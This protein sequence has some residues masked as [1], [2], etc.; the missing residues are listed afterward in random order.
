MSQ[1]KAEQIIVIGASEH[2]LKNVSLKI[3]RDTLTVF[4]GVSGSG[5]SSL[6]LILFSKKVSAVL[7]N[8]F[9]PMRVNFSDN[10]TNQKSSIL[11]D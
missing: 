6:H 4:T 1:E 11:K 7:L 2:N 5:K 10:L 3:P 9:R 8:H